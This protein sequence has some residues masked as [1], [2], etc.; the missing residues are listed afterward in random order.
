MTA[1][2]DE[3]VVVYRGPHAAAG[4]LKGLLEEA[5][6]EGHLWGEAR[7]RQLSPLTPQK[8]FGMDVAIARKDIQRAQPI[9]KKLIDEKL[10]DHLI[11]PL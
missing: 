11:P 6:I 7:Q 8:G 9:V 1:S 5:G 10:F 3:P 4:F 2:P